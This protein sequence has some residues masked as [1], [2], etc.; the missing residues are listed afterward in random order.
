MSKIQSF[1]ENSLKIRIEDESSKSE[2]SGGS[3]SSLPISRSFESSLN[4]V[5][6]TQK[7]LTSH[8]RRTSV[9]N[10]CLD[11]PHFQHNIPVAKRQISSSPVKTSYLGRNSKRRLSQDSGIVST[12][13]YISCYNVSESIILS[14]ALKYAPSE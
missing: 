10:G 2:S 5:N 9:S 4:N 3:E 13:G 8:N 7:Y 1:S 14:T 12:R 11:V 6:E